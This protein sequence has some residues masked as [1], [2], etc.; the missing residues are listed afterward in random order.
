MGN[1]YGD[2]GK[3]FQTAREESEKTYGGGFLGIGSSQDAYE[4][5]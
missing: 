1:A 3:R 2:I 5:A 4:K